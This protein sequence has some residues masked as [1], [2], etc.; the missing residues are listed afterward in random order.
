MKKL[1]FLI[2]LISLS[3][4][5]LSGCAGTRDIVKKDGQGNVLVDQNFLGSIEG[6]NPNNPYYYSSSS[7]W[8]KKGRLDNQVWEMENGPSDYALAAEMED[9]SFY[10]FQADIDDQDNVERVAWMAGI[11][12]EPKIRIL[13]RNN[14]PVSP[15]SSD[16][17]GKT[18]AG[19]NEDAVRQFII[20]SVKLGPE[21]DEY[22]NVEDRYAQ[23]S[24]F[25][26]SWDKTAFPKVQYLKQIKDRASEYNIVPVEPGSNE[27]VVDIRKGRYIQLC[28]KVNGKEITVNVD[29]YK[30]KDLIL[31]GLATII[32]GKDYWLKIIVPPITEKIKEDGATDADWK[33][34]DL[35]LCNLRPMRY[36]K[37][38]NYVKTGF[39]RLSTKDLISSDCRWINMRY[40]R[41]IEWYIN[42]GALG[43]DPATGKPMGS[44]VTSPGKLKELS[45]DLY[46]QHKHSIHFPTATRAPKG[47]P[48]RD[49][50]EEN[51][52][53]V[54]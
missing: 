10:V 37:M 34:C 51:L 31:E 26:V 11:T 42:D 13:E 29:P 24:R 49:D 27:V 18:I 25:V 3:L 32:L 38:S 19:I 6:S 47:Q 33:P 48:D 20:R 5:W 43:Y 14:Y 12:K 35:N 45:L 2:I 50:Q 9:S 23:D 16:Q 39:I 7:A 30:E 54:P 46:E 17:D 40:Q 28:W 52:F 36:A 8:L 1:F 15:D 4:I 44:F 21:N 41:A 22:Y 53:I